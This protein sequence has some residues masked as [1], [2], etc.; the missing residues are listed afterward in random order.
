MR[1]HRGS[2]DRY[3]DMIAY[4]RQAMPG[5]EP[6]VPQMEPTAERAAAEEQCREQ[7]DRDA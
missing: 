6:D 7:R 4:Q 5:L 3:G 1:F 2:V